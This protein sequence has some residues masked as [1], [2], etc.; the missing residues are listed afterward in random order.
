MRIL[1]LVS[2]CR[3]NGN[4][5]RIVNLIEKELLYLAEKEK[6]ELEIERIPLADL[7]LRICCGCRTCFNNSEVKCPLKDDL[8]S[9]RDKLIQV[10]GILAAS[11]VYVEDVNAIMKNW[12]DRMAFNCHRPAYA[13]KSA[14]V[15]TTSGAGSSNHSLK[16][17]IFAFMSWGMKIAGKSSF[18]T[19][20]LMDT[21]DMELKFRSKIKEVAQTL[22]SAIR[23]N[24]TAKPSLYSLIVFKVQQKYRLKVGRNH[25]TYDYEY[26]FDKGWLE[27]KCDFYIPHQS[28][29]IK[30]LIARFIAAIAAKFLSAPV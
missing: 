22:F 30:K 25:N 24:S 7:G 26:W 18:K 4:T 17:M 23:N 29:P 5:E 2:S 16:T 15:V 13:G 21:V 28:N 8:L 20:A 1:S 12:I 9:I 3:K 11:P 6:I 10:D 27:N 19:G 14:Y